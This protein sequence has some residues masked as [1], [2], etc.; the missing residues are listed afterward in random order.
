MIAVPSATQI[1]RVLDWLM[2]F[3]L[4]PSRPCTYGG[5]AST[6]FSFLPTEPAT[7]RLISVNGTRNDTPI[8]TAALN[9]VSRRPAVR[10]TI[11]LAHPP[12]HPQPRRPSRDQ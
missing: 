12:P 1:V 5:S 10:T 11:T 4:P 3:W 6:A 8:P 9:S 2:K 7:V